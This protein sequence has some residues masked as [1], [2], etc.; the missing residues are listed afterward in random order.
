MTVL[1][2]NF[3]VPNA[4]FAITALVAL[5]LVVA[6]IVM[7]VTVLVRRRTA[8]A[9]DTTTRAEQKPG[10]EDGPRRFTYPARDAQGS[11]FEG[12]VPL[13]RVENR[14]SGAGDARREAFDRRVPLLQ[15]VDRATGKPRPRPRP[16]PRRTGSLAARWTAALA[17]YDTVMTEWGA[18][19]SDPLS[20][21]EHSALL[22]VTQP[23]TAAFVEALGRAQD[24]RAL[25]GSDIPRD[26][27]DVVEFED[28]ARRVADAWADARRHAAHVGYGWMP[29]KDRALAERADTLLRLAADTSASL[30]ERVAAAEQATKVL[31]SIY[32]IVLPEPALEVIA[33]QRRLALE[34][35][36]SG[37]ASADGPI[38]SAEPERES[39]A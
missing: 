3:L 22:D 5:L 4:S 9:T 33:S 38:L 26:R 27:A 35:W 24:R 19:A 10:A 21:L 37:G 25:L 11:A 7:V 18:I 8:I 30:H 20:A 31:H 17:R 13:F 36:Q 34:A 1:E 2:S 32:A 28:L 29:D 39:R 6:L 16:V 23:R 12:R 15:V 14:S